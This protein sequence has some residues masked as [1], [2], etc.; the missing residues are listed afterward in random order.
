MPVVISMSSIVLLSIS[1]PSLYH[2]TWGRGRPVMV[3]LSRTFSPALRVSTWSRDHSIPG[4][5]D[6]KKRKKEKLN[7]QQQNSELNCFL[8]VLLHL[9]ISLRKT[10][11]L[12][13]SLVMMYPE[14]F[15]G[16]LMV[17]TAFL[18]ITLNSNLSPGDKPVTVN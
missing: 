11:L 6:S 9:Y 3:Q 15:D 8:N 2:T 14:E 16:G 1:L 4:A 17:P 13:S 10:S 5:T 7:N 12:L 18:A